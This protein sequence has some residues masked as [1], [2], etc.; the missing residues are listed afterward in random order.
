MGRRGERGSRGGGEGGRKR[1]GT[2]VPRIPNPK[3]IPERDGSGSVSWDADLRFEVPGA[4]RLLCFALE[5]F[6]FVL[7]R[8]GLFYSDGHV[9]AEL[10]QLERVV[11][12]YA[13]VRGVWARVAWAGRLEVSGRG[14]AREGDGNALASPAHQLAGIV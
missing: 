9:G 4:C 11:S 3:L 12:G 14:G 5:A 10:L 13:A 2:L 7:G 1:G 8:S 6:I